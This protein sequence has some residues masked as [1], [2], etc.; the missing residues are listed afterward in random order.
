MTVNKPDTLDDTVCTCAHWFEEQQFVYCDM[1][2]QQRADTWR[3][4]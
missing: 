4:P 2:S 3:K 1:Y